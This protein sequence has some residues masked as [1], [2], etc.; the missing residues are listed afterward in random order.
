M[1]S[2][3]H[4]RV[5]FVAPLGSFSGLVGIGRTRSRAV[6]GA[7]TSGHVSLPRP[8]GGSRAGAQ[9]EGG[10]GTEE[11]DTT[12][13]W[14]PSRRRRRSPHSLPA[15]PLH[16]A[17]SAKQ[18]AAPSPG[19]P[20]TP[21]SAHSLGETGSP[22]GDTWRSVFNPGCAELRGQRPW[23]EAVV[24]DC[25]ERR[26]GGSFGPGWAAILVD[27]QRQRQ[28]VRSCK[29]CLPPVLAFRP[30]LFSLHSAAATTT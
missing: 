27:D 19:S 1:G 29:G 23:F 8:P 7:S 5:V 26:W 16:A 25:A 15:H 9:P 6:V 10:E 22:R 14:C 18:D 3:R 21:S 24:V 2:R 12:A 13:R 11:K 20:S 28:P 17:V 4:V 30:F